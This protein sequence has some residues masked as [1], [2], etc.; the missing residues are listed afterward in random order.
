MPA[1]FCV[2]TLYRQ[3]FCQRTFMFEQE[4]LYPQP[5]RKARQTAI[6]TDDTMTGHHYWQWVTPIGSAYCTHCM[7]GTDASSQPFVIQGFSIGN[8]GKPSPYPL[9]ELGSPGVKGNRETSTLARKVL[10][11]LRGCLCQ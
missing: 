4:T 1:S 5:S 9:L 3:F 8:L 10:S 2:W 6:T 11:Q 7:R